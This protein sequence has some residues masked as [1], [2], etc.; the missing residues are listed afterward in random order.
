MLTEKSIQ[1]TISGQTDVAVVIPV[2]NCKGY[3]REAV[4]SVLGQPYQKISIVL[5]DDGSTDGSGQL[6]DEIAK[7]SNRVTVLHQKNAGVSA[8]RNAGIEHILSADDG[9]RYIAFLDA[10][11]GW[12]SNFFNENT[13][14]LL[15]N[16]YDLIGFQSCN[17]NA[18]LRSYDV[19]KT[20]TDGLHSGGQSS[21]WLHVTQSFAAMLYSYDFLQRNDIRFF[22][23]LKYSE[24]KIFSMQCMYLADSIYLENRLLYLYRHTGNSAM[25]RRKYGITYYVPIIDGYIKL[26]FLM[27]QQN[28]V[29][30]PLS[31]SRLMASIYIMDM[32]GE[33][34]RL[35]RR[36]RE[37]DALFASHP[38]YI[39]IAEATGEYADLKPNP[40]FIQYRE[41]PVR[42]IIRNNLSG[43][44]KICKKIIRR[45]LHFIK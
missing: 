34:Y 40:A 35:F 43:G 11:D 16:G 18:Q 33:H 44:I 6:C 26:D 42:Y 23:G 19:P 38:N 29:R 13:I 4:D 3:I 1:M 22:E 12:A 20:M 15:Q 8:A 45:L 21:V 28:S 25:N 27:R 36:K 7:E 2:F 17:C 9:V 41:H 37:L 24:D 5:V 39:S 30:P 32:V 10:D 14:K 31:A